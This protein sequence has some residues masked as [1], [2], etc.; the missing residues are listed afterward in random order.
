MMMS[1]FFRAHEVNPPLS[2]IYELMVLSKVGEERSPNPNDSLLI[3]QESKAN[4]S[5]HA[6]QSS[7]CFPRSDFQVTWPLSVWNTSRRR[8][9]KEPWNHSL[10]QQYEQL[11][12][13]SHLAQ[14][15]SPK[16]KLIGRA[17]Q[18]FIVPTIPKLTIYHQ[19]DRWKEKPPAWEGWLQCFS[20]ATFKD[21]WSR[22]WVGLKLFDGAANCPFQRG[23]H[24]SWESFVV[25]PPAPQQSHHFGVEK[26][27]FD[28]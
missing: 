26:A 1:F 12:Q 21:V 22:C 9:S 8:Q 27:G 5:S 19:G 14:R 25:T 24:R 18:P 11:T 28:S 7:L 17:L 16:A 15:N 23:H 6:T 13:K 2:Y 20:K 3:F 10:N 4:L